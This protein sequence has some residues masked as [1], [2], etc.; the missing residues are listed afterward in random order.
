MDFV[1]IL[2]TDVLPYAETEL[3]IDHRSE[4][5]DK[6]NNLIETHEG[7]VKNNK[8]NEQK[9]LGFEVSSDGSNMNN[10][11]AKKKRANGI[12]AGQFSLTWQAS[13]V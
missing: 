9:C 4:H 3:L 1:A 6:Y 7:K 2:S 5:Q 11:E 13:L 12:I 8:I 10:M